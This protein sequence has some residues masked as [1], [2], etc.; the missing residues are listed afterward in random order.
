MANDVKAIYKAL[1]D[2]NKRV[3]KLSSQKDLEQRVTA[4][5]KYI[6]QLD[7]EIKLITSK[8]TEIGGFLKE[9]LDS[10]D[11][12]LKKISDSI[13]YFLRLFNFFK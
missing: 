5:E 9:M 8:V 3:D 10:A 4:I 12:I 11:G 13:S 6:N 1:E 2:L 7:E